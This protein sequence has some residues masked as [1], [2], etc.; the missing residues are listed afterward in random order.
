MK[1]ANELFEEAYHLHYTR[2][3]LVSAFYIYQEVISKYPKNPEA[4]HSKSQIQNIEQNS[5]WPKQLEEWQKKIDR[6]EKDK[7]SQ[8]DDAFLYEKFLAEIEGQHFDHAVWTKAL[9]IHYGDEN[10]AKYEYV[11]LKVEDFKAHLELT[12]SETPAENVTRMENLHWSE[13]PIKP[14]VKPLYRPERPLSAEKSPASSKNIK[15]HAIWRWIFWFY[16]LFGILGFLA[17]VTEPNSRLVNF[18]GTAICFVIAYFAH[19][20]N[21]KVVISWHKFFIVL[22]LTSI[23]LGFYLVATNPNKSELGAFV[24]FLIFGGIIQIAICLAIISKLNELRP[25]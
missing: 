23:V 19:N 8:G 10:K 4:S 18:A 16:F 6:Q 24:V 3:D 15:Q 12:P 20:N 11:K 2:N 7:V 17:A 25:G 1:S 5:D 9:T 13:R 21:F 14:D 22:G